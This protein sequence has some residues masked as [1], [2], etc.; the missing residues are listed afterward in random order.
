MLSKA[1]KFVIFYMFITI[2]TRPRH[3]RAKKSCFPFQHT[4]HSF[5]TYWATIFCTYTRQLTRF[6][7]PKSRESCHISTGS[8]CDERSQNTIC[9]CWWPCQSLALRRGRWLRSSW[10]RLWGKKYRVSVKRRNLSL[11]ISAHQA[12]PHVCG[13]LQRY[14]GSSGQTDITELDFATVAGWSGS[15]RWAMGYESRWIR[16][17]HGQGAMM[18]LR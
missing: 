3:Y 18:R 2:F 11:L 5:S 7:P 17:V 9:S 4:T 8:I 14:N 13:W 1:S 15:A 12:S 10:S 6:P 16:T